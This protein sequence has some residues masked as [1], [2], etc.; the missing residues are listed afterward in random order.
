MAVEVAV[1]DG[2]VEA[3]RGSPDQQRVGEEPV[4]QGVVGLAGGA[5]LDAVERP[6]A[7]SCWRS[8]SGRSSR[9]QGGHRQ[10][11]REQLM[12]G[13]R[14]GVEHQGLA[15]GVQ[16]ESVAVDGVDERFVERDPHR[17]AVA[18]ALGHDVGVLGEPG[19]GVPVEPAAV[20]LQRLRQVPV[21]QR[22]HGG[23][24]VLEQASTS[25]S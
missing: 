22:D 17:D 8:R 23:D 10:P 19:G 6:P 21:E 9:A 4:V 13:G 2:Q 7:C 15:G 25:R 3:L 16:A 14:Q 24:V 12:V 5:V 20:V 11:V 18:E 1:A